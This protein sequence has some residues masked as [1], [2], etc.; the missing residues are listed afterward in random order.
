VPD[1][2]QQFLCDLETTS[3]STEVWKLI[4]RLGQELRLPFVD[5]ISASNYSDWKKT[6]FIRPS[7]D[8]AW[9]QDFEENPKSDRWSYFRGH[10]MDRLTPITIG[11]EFIDE[12]HH[13]P[14]N[15]VE[16]LRV[17]AKHGMRAGFSI[18]LR[19]HSPPQSALM[20]FAGDHS[21]REMTAIVKAHGWTL[22]AAALAGHQRYIYHFAQ[23]FTERNQ[24]TKK[25]EDLLR[26]IGLGFKDKSI[27]K[28]LE[29]SISAVRQRMKVLM[30]RTGVNSRPELAALAMGIGIL[31][32]P[33]YRP[34]SG[35]V[36]TLIEMDD[37]GTR[38]KLWHA[39]GY[40]QS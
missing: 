30:Q 38:T 40:D 37:G 20:T 39:S 22:H 32:D 34:D 11:M 19:Q 27:A 31:P 28:E 8:P 18:P 1:L 35:P 4:V 26:L 14:A 7:Y 36:S 5:F 29:V 21:R 2:L 13:I 6:L 10:A 33:L 24:I 3:H 12:Y 23:E 16:V 15:R 25:Q 9:Q 17:A